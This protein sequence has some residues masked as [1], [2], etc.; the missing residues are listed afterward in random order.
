[1][2]P[3]KLSR[4]AFLRTTGLGAVGLY[5]SGALL[6]NLALMQAAAANGRFTDYRALVCVFLEGGNDACNTIVPRAA[7]PQRAIYEAQRSGGTSIVIP[8]PPLELRPLAATLPVNQQYGFNPNLA[9]L[10]PLYTQ[11]RLAVVANVGPLMQPTTKQ[12]FVDRSVPLPP[13]LTSHSDQVM[14]WY[15]GLNRTTANT[16]WAGRIADLL[17]GAFQN[18]RLSMNVTVNGTTLFLTGANVIQYAINPGGAAPV[19]FSGDWQVGNGARASFDALRQLPQTHLLTREYQGTLNRSIALADEVNSALG[20]TDPYPPEFNG[21][22]D[23]EASDAGGNELKAQL[24]LVGRMLRARNTLGM[25]RQIFF[26]RLN[27]FD[28]HGQQN[29]EHRD[30]LARLNNA[31]RDFW[32]L[33]GRLGLRDGVV[34]YTMT[35]FGRTLST[36]GDGTDH[37][38]GG[39]QF[40]MGGPVR[41]GDIHG[42]MPDLRIDGTESNDWGHVVPTIATDQYFA[43]LARWY[44]V[45][46]SELATIFP[47]LATFTAAGW[48][49]TLG[50]LDLPPS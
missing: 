6:S 37:A 31:L 21:L 14:H 2:T 8:A 11:Q 46:S 50:F 9:D 47:N 27:G 38:W 12:Q 10:H 40:V 1:M 15:T 23:T 41:G 33:L 4:R 16:G 20:P 17:G 22:F 39:H 26:V 34:T 3:K 7:H 48:P 49:G 45:S 25:R 28:T 5:G 35:D 44:G 13:Q 29:V 32:T 36:N 24:R 43:T 42:R 19:E 18:P 30:A